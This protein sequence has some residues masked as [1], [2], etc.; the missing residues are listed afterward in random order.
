MS[1]SS[2]KS[3]PSPTA[4]QTAGKGNVH[5]G[6]GDMPFNLRDTLSSIVVREANFGEFLAALKQFGRYAS[7]H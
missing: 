4:S 7:K 1:L 2:M 5:A 3:A 6:E